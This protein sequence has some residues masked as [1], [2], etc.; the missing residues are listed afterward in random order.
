MTSQ[1][2]CPYSSSDFVSLL[3][4]NDVD[5]YP[6]YEALR[7]K[8]DIVWDKKLQGWALLADEHC[9]FVETRE[10]LFRTT[11]ADATPEIKAVKGGETIPLLMG[12]RHDK[13]RRFHM[14]LLSPVAVE[15]VRQAH[16]RPVIDWLLDRVVPSGKADLA[17]DMAYQLPTRMI[18]SMFGLDWKNDDL[19]N[20]IHDHHN[21]I[22]EW[23]GRRNPGGELGQRGLAASEALNDILRPAI[24]DRRQNPSDDLISA[25]WE[26]AP[27]EYGPI[28]EKDVQ[29]ICREL[30]FA[31]GDTTMQSL[32]NAIFLLL[33]DDDARAAVEADRKTA[34]NHFVEEALRLYPS[35]QWRFRIA[36]QDIELGGQ[37]IK[38]DDVVISVK[39]AAN[40]DPSRY[41]CPADIKLDRPR[42][43][44][45]LT[46]NTGPRTCAG[47]RLARAELREMIQALLDRLPGLRL[48]KN[49]PPPRL[50]GVYM[51]GFRPLNVVFDEGGNHE[52]G[53]P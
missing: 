37:S 7:S 11:Y 36:N 32:A 1:A 26:K 27:V 30:L 34:L 21:T 28:D 10:D 19:V 38:K 24:L 15:A 16:I 47:A 31:G 14:K 13:A 8:G 2:N 40:R 50:S 52:T 41:D 22:V 3:D 49:S 51:Q 6:A 18:L 33:T 48:D 29:A 43:T 9:R 53:N 44:D 46:F 23:I 12:E 35:A 5:P 4:F 39:A 42:P 45:H 17:L 20:S 25:I